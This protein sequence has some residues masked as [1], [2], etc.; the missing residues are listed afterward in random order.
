MKKSPPSSRGT[1]SL[2]HKNVAMA[3]DTKFNTHKR[4]LSLL[5][6]DSVPKRTCLIRQ[7]DNKP[8]TLMNLP[9]EVRLHTLNSALWQ[10]EPLRVSALKRC[11]QVELLAMQN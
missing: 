10:A 11:W 5:F 2:Q 1:S 8:R 3:A 4:Q 9:I 7:D 6:E